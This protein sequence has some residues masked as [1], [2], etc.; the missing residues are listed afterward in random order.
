M[1]Q[2]NKNIL[3]LILII[4][5]YASTWLAVNTKV[6]CSLI[7]KKKKKKWT[8]SLCPKAQT[9]TLSYTI[10]QKG[11]P[12]VSVYLQ[13]KISHLSHTCGRNTAYCVLIFHLNNPWTESTIWC[14]CSR[15]SKRPFITVF[16]TVLYASTREIPTLREGS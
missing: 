6:F 1:L 7:L 14:I 9:F 15:Y 11:N 5:V 16:P 2:E 8:G 3:T 12:S 4:E 10:W 13:Y